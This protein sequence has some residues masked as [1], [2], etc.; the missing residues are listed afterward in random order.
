MKARVRVRC[1]A[2]RAERWIGPGEIPDG[3]IPLCPECFM[4]QVAIRAEARSDGFADA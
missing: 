3:E 4:P 2:C 1:I